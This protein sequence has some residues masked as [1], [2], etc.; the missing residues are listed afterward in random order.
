MKTKKEIMEQKDLMSLQIM[1]LL[2]NINIFA[3]KKDIIVP[4]AILPFD[5]KLLQKLVEQR[6]LLE[7]VLK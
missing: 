6:N 4:G 3:E 5:T 1:G 7:W 2:D